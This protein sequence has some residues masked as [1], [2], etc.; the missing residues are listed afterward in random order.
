MSELSDHLTRLG[1][2]KIDFIISRWFLCC[3]FGVLPAEPPQQSL[4][5]DFVL[6]HLKQQG[7][8]RQAENEAAREHLMTSKFARMRATM[9]RAIDRSSSRLS[10]AASTEASPACAPPRARVHMCACTCMC[11]RGAPR[12][13]AAAPRAAAARRAAPAPL[14]SRSRPAECRAHSARLRDSE[15]PFQQRPL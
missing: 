10:V 9:A 13:R 15:T 3:Y 4:T 5:N 8:L 14:H 11:A 12:C 6:Q 2:P 7:L 1:F